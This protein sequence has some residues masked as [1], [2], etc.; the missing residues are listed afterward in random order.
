M[1]GSLEPRKTID[2]TVPPPVDQFLTR[3]LEA[4]TPTQDP[5]QV[6]RHR[7][8]AVMIFIKHVPL[9][10]NLSNRTGQILPRRCRVFTKIRMMNKPFAADL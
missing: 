3:N 1:S 2:Q 5:E 6:C 4:I 10:Q 8:S 9:G 7:G